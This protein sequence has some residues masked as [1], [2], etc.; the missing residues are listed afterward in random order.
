M[1]KLRTKVSRFIRNVKVSAATRRYNARMLTV[2]EKKL[3][4]WVANEE[5][6]DNACSVEEIIDKMNV[7]PDAFHSYFRTVIGKRFLSW[8]KEIR[9][10]KAQE[11]LLSSPEMTVRQAAEYVGISDKTNF[12]NQFREVTG[13]SP[14][15]WTEKNRK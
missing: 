7:P 2:V 9:I 10:R 13:L 1:N 15:E 6:R 11:L 3:E 12:R 4:E 8:R 14:A 5:Y